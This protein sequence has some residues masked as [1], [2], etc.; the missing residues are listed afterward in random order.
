MRALF[1]VALVG[2]VVVVGIAL[3]AWTP[4]ALV[5]YAVLLAAAAVAVVRR[6]RAAA[7]PA[8]RTCD[9]CTSTVF[10]PVEVR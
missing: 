7:R 5:P 4:Y 8:G 1:L 10:D 9:C 3:A 6:V 2:V